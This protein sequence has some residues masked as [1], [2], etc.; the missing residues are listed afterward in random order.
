MDE[1]DSEMHHE[2]SKHSKHHHHPHHHGRHGKGRLLAVGIIAVIIIVIAVGLFYYFGGSAVKVGSGGYT[3]DITSTGNL[4]MI[5]GQEYMIRLVSYNSTYKTAHIYLTRTP[6]FTNPTLNVTLPF[7]SS[8]KVNYGANYAFVQFALEESNQTS[9]LVSI[10][11]LPQSLGI[12]PDSQDISMLGYS[13][14]GNVTGFGSSNSTIK[15][16]ATTTIGSGGSSTSTATTTA[17]TTTSTI[18]QN[19][20]LIA[21]NTTLKGDKYYAIILNLSTLYTQSSGCTQSLYN[22][23]YIQTYKTAP[24][25][26]NDYYNAS[27]NAPYALVRSNVNNGHGNYEIEFV[28]LSQN[29][30][31]NDTPAFAAVVNVSTKTVKTDTLEGIF[32]GESYATFLQNYK[33]TKGV[34]NDCAALIG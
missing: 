29:S 19:T 23:T 17:G 20:T 5:N 9:A 25:G 21:I 27:E 32:S 26:Q 8:V 15:T 28:S 33:S 13:V 12:S 31:F 34:G 11:L 10:S 22:T 18:P 4:Y 7:N 14:I 24:S 1:R 16:T 3:G 30:Y 2:L 6:I